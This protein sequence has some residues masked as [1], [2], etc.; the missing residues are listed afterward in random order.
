MVR[1]TNTC[2]IPTYKIN[3]LRVKPQ[4]IHKLDK[5]MTSNSNTTMTQSMSDQSPKPAGQDKPSTLDQKIKQIQISQTFKLQQPK[6]Q[7]T[8]Q[9]CQ[10]NVEIKCQL[11]TLNCFRFSINNCFRFLINEI[12]QKVQ[13]RIMQSK[14]FRLLYDLV[15]IT[16]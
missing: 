4:P 7:M 6:W 10:I 13:I 8:R 2:I 5:T 16:I 12:W 3:I 11:V 14:I 1:D 15:L 9:N